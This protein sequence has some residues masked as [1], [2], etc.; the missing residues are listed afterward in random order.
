M[1]VKPDITEPNHLHAHRI[2]RVSIATTS[3]AT[4]D[5]VRARAAATI[6]FFFRPNISLRQ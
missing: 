3:A 1:S 6:V 4:L 2:P 5:S